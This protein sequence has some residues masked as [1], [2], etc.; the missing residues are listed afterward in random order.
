[1]KLESSNSSSPNA[2][3][4]SYY[5]FNDV[6]G[7]RDFLVYV[8]SYS[9]DMFPE[10]EWRS[11]NEQMNLERAFVGLSYGLTLFQVHEK[12][13]DV[14]SKCR[15]LIEQAYLEYRAGR[16]LDGQHLLEQVEDLIRK[17]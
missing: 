4:A 8:L 10:E 5:G 11:P 9:P 12:H 7:F 13:G 15:A 3:R 16:D 6:V 2:D 1:M 17:V 14:V